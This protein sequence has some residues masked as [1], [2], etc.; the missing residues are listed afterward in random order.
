MRH[1]TSQSRAH[2]TCSTEF[3]FCQCQSVLVSLCVSCRV[4][5]ITNYQFCTNRRFYIYWKSHV[6]KWDPGRFSQ[7]TKAT[8]KTGYSNLILS[9]SNGSFVAIIN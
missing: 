5:N 7:V 4:E 6:S 9:Q 3:L 8:A 1:C 2:T